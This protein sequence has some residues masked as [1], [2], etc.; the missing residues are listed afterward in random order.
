[1]T[2]A[3]LGGADCHYAGIGTH[4]MP[5]E[6]LPQL[7]ANLLVPNFP[8]DDLE[9]A[10]A[11]VTAAIERLSETAGTAPIEVP[12][13][14]IAACF[15]ADSVV[16]ILTRLAADGPGWAPPAAPAIDRKRLD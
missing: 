3:R 6:R 11:A 1:M 8:A 2:G 9:A 10:H 5:S 16:E 14:Q 7:A 13:R 4:Y 15:S 12:R